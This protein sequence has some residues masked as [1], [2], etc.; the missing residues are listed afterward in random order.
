MKV[1]IVCSYRSYMASGV[2]AF[3]SDQVDCVRQCG[4]ET[5][6]FLVKGKGIAGYI[7]N[8]FQLKKKLREYRP[9]IIHAHYGLCGLLANLQRRIPVVTT[10]HGSDINEPSNQKFSKLSI[11]LSAWNIFVSKKMVD[12]IKVNRKYSVIA[13]GVNTDLFFPMDAN[14]CRK[15]MGFDDDTKYALFSKEFG[16]KVKNYPLAKAAI[17][18]LEGWKLVELIGYTHEQVALLMNACDVGLMTSFSEGSPQFIKEALACGMPIVSTDV[19]DVVEV[20][21]GVKNARICT[22]EA[23]D[24]AEKIKEVVS[25]GKLNGSF[26]DRFD[27]VS[28]AKR[29]VGIYNSVLKK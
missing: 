15:K 10:Y 23:A 26:D 6:Y 22:Y 3:I 25:V 27:N 9:D 28:I 24:V 13:C 4:V 19:G 16:D 11:C 12:K 8:L 29:I 17:E 5:D 21:A 2:A 1:L 18:R 14:D 7:R 20:I